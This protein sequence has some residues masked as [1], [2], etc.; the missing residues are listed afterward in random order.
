MEGYDP[1]NAA[2]LIKCY[3]DLTESTRQRWFEQIR[4]IGV[5]TRAETVDNDAGWG[6]PDPLASGN[7]KR[8]AEHESTTCLEI[9]YTVKWSPSLCSH[10]LW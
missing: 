8:F 4:G 9:D 5:V 2:L 10:S 6:G 3:Q 7:R 1:K